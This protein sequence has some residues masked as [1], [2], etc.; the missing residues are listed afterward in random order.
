MRR[1]C[2]DEKAEGGDGEEWVRG[3]ERVE[4]EAMKA[5]KKEERDM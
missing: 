1:G 2:K 3:R 5:T 4:M